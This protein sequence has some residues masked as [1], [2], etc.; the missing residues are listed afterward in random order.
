M[1]FQPCSVDGA[2]VV[3]LA[4]HNDERGHFAR[5]WCSVEFAQQ[6]IDF[7]PLQ[8]NILLSRRA[9]TLRGLHHQVEPSP[10]AKLVR[11]TRGAIFDVV[12]D[13]RPQSP[14]YLKWY[15]LE[16]SA[17]NGRMLYLPP[18]C[19]HGCQSLVDET[20]IYYM[21]SALF[22]AKDARGLRYDDPALGIH[23]PLAVTSLSQQD[24]NW[25]LLGGSKV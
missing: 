15:G 24:A 10:E 9:G 5:A 22:A 3:D 8:A 12:V 18:G 4:P 17:A 1:K 21:A 16:L 2:W 25:P 14:T 6:G 7:V 20:E 13:L 19:A 11:C 23:W